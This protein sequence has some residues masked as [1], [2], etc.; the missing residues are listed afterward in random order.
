MKIIVFGAAG[1]TGHELLKQGIMRG[2]QMIAFDVREPEISPSQNLQV[3]TGNVLDQSLVDQII[4]GHNVVIGELGVRPGIK[5]PIVSEGNRVI[6]HAM[7]KHGM[8]RLITQSAFGANESWKELPFGLKLAHNVLLGSM[9]EDKNKMEKIVQN[10]GLDWT[11]VRPIRLNNGPK[12][13]HYQAGE[14][15]NV[16]INPFISRADVADFILNILEDPSTFQ[17]ILAITY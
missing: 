4:P 11:I 14:R 12:R 1:Q 16:G 17:K 10:S 6:I 7:Q 3:F 13:G 9:S 8:R 15:V 5:Q 2:H